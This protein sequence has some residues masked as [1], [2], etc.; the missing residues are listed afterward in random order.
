MMTYC[1]IRFKN[2]PFCSKEGKRCSAISTSMH[3]DMR[4]EWFSSA[5]TNNDRL[6]A[7]SLGVNRFVDSRV[8]SVSWRAETNGWNKSY[9]STHIMKEWKHT[10]RPKSFKR[11]SKSS[12]RTIRPSSHGMHNK[13][14]LCFRSVLCVIEARLENMRGTTV[15]QGN[16]IDKPLKF[17]PVE[18]ENFS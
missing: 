15:W 16:P 6:T 13:N 1:N 10:I 9:S 3:W 18:V 17:R 14:R 8:S 12:S 4:L 11:D 7:F 5:P 2:A